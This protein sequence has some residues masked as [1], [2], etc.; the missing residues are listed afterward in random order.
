MPESS[1]RTRSHRSSALRCPFWRRKIL[2]MRSRL[3]ERLPP[4]GRRPEKSKVALFDAERRAAAASGG[5]IGIL[6]R[7]TTARD[8]V[9]EVDL[10]TIQIP[11]ADRVHEQLDA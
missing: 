8:R 11:N 7:E 9:Y 2:R 3:V 10:G 5:G 6:D 1:W 4:A